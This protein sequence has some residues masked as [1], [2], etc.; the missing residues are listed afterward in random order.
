MVMKRHAEGVAGHRHELG[1]R[2]I[3][4]MLPHLKTFN[5]ARCYCED[6]YTGFN[7]ETEWDECWD[8]PC[9][10]GGEYKYSFVSM[11]VNIKMLLSQWR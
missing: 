4:E 9:L 5:L 10:N 2:S 8:E 11:G 1:K 3:I 6:G 7:C